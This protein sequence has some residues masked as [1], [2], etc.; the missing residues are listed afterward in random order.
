MAIILASIGQCYIEKK[1]YQNALVYLK[2]SILNDEQAGNE[3]GTALTLVLQG[4]V[5]EQ[6]N[7]NDSAIHCYNKAVEIT[8]KYGLLSEKKDAAKSLAVIFEKVGKPVEAL[9]NYKLY[10]VLND[11]LNKNDAAGPA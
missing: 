4:N 6:M 5:Y 1:L 7:N 9:K 2:S 3:A 10:N 11:S 8:D